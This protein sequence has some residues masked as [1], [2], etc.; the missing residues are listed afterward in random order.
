MGY[1]LAQ[2]GVP[3]VRQAELPIRYKE[4]TLNIS[5]R[6]DMLIEDAVVLGLKR[7]TEVTAVHEAQLLTYLRLAKKRVG[8]LIN[9][10]TDLVKHGIKRRVL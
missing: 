4:A 9:F 10:N 3:F 7:V 8:L 1:E 5:C 6:F 2:L